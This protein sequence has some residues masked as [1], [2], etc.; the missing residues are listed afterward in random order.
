MGLLI[1]SL[2]AVFEFVASQLLRQHF[3]PLTFSMNYVLNEHLLQGAMPFPMFNLEKTHEHHAGGTARG[4]ES[5]KSALFTA[6][7][8]WVLPAALM[9]WLLRFLI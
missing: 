2:S 8:L 5:R 6:A 4:S 9:N 3:V 7:L 1:G